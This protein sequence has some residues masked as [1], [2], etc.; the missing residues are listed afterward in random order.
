MTFS[1]KKLEYYFITFRYP[2][3]HAVCKNT[4]DIQ[5]AVIF[6]KKHN[7]RVTVKSE[8]NDPWGRSSAHNSLTINLMEMKQ[9]SVSPEATARSEYGEIT[10]ETGVTAKVIYKKVTSCKLNINIVRDYVCVNLTHS[11]V[12]INC[13]SHN[14]NQK[15]RHTVTFWNVKF[16]LRALE[17]RV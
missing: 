8:G 10:V 17:F 5:L 7:L 1:Y 2:I 11:R 9:I 4:E 12:D 6:A 16:V 14:L 15:G 13:G 3:V